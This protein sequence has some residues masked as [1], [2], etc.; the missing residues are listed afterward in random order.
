MDF[1]CHIYFC[2]FS[3]TDED[4]I[5]YCA[6]CGGATCNEHIATIQ[7]QGYEEFLCDECWV[8]GN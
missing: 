6:E 5:V 1:H 2:D 4:E 3:T 8:R 7:H